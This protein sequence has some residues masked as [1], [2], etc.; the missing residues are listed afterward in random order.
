MRHFHNLFLLLLLFEVFSC[1]SR[2]NGQEVDKT[3]PRYGEISNNDEYKKADD[4][5]RKKALR[6]Y[7][8]RGI[9]EMENNNLAAKKD[10]EIC[11]Q[12][13]SKDP[14]LRKL[15]GLA[16]LNL[17]DKNGACKD[18]AL[19]EGLGDTQAGELIKQNCK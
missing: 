15:L 18:F 7:V 4:E 5:F 12:L 8:N 13:D 9:T 16:K 10:F 19:A 2:T 6:N 11:V 14:G 1:N 17:K 3:K